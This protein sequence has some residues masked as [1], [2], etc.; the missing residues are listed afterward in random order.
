MTFQRVRWGG[1]QTLSHNWKSQIAVNKNSDSKFHTKASSRIWKRACLGKPRSINSYRW[2]VDSKLVDQVLVRDQKN[3]EG[4]LKV[5]SQ[6]GHEVMRFFTI[7]SWWGRTH[8]SSHPRSSNQCVCDGRCT[9]SHL[10]HAH[11]LLCIHCTYSRTFLCVLHTCTAQ[12]CLQCACRHL[13]VISPSPFSCF[14][15]ACSCCSLTV[16]SRPLPTS[17]TLPTLT[18]TTSCPTF[19]TWRRRWSALRP[20]TSCLDTWPSPSP[21]QVMSPKK[22]DKNTSV[23]DD[24]TLIKDPDHNI[25]DFSKTTNENTSQFGVHTLFESSVLHVSHGE[26]PLQGESKESMQ[27]GNRCLT[28]KKKEK[29]LRWVLQSWCLWKSRRNSIGSHSLT[30]HRE[31]DSDRDPRGHLQWRAQQAILGENSVRRKLGSTEYNME[32]QNFGAKKLRIRIIRAAW[33]RI[34]KTTITGSRSMGRSSPA[35]ENT[36]VWWIGDEELSSPGLLRKKLPRIWRIEKDAAMKRRILKNHE[37]WKSFLCSVIRNHV[38]WVYWE[39]KYEDYKN[40]WY[41]LKVRKSSVILTH[42][43]AMTYLRSSSSSYSLEFK[44]ARLGQKSSTSSSW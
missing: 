8:R 27:S 15:R 21:P 30:T 14:T 13:S 32:T 7:F 40:Y 34:S 38:Q 35:W 41:I 20:R 44:T 25:S 24:T 1:V 22:F 23:D 3:L 2:L 10:L 5:F 4:S 19:P 9:H 43:A 17:T 26:F 16:T 31:F 37:D 42:W 33:A 11:F 39:I 28:E 36:L 12:G 6:D 18:S 29:V